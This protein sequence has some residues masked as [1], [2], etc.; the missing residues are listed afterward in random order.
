MTKAKTTKEQ[1][2]GEEVAPQFRKLVGVHCQYMLQCVHVR[3]AKSQTFLEQPFV[4]VEVDA[5]REM[6]P[7]NQ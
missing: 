1:E 6:L 5:A 3:C 2:I 4:Y 7:S